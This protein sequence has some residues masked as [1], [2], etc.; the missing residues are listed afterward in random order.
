MNFVYLYRSG[1][2]Y[3]FYKKG[4]GLVFDKKEK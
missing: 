2:F 3:E 1:D 4:S